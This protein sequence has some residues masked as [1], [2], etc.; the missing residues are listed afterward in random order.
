MWEG[1]ILRDMQREVLAVP[2]PRNPSLG[3]A[4]SMHIHSAC[5]ICNAGTIRGRVYAYQ[6]GE[7]DSGVCSVCS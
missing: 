5:D 3:E 4:S 6:R 7:P 1:G 2:D